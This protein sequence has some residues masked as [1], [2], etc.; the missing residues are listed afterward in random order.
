MVSIAYRQPKKE[1]Y[2]YFIKCGDAVK[3]GV[4]DNP[5]DR[6][7]TLS[8]GSPEKL[9]ILDALEMMGD[10]EAECHRRLRHLRINRE[11]FRYTNE[12]DELIMEL[13]RDY[14]EVCPECGAVH[15]RCDKYG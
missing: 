1:K 4:S 7:D 3:I 5:E 15:R 13:K 6:L 11:W 8:T 2:L 10:H 14:F 9:V 12:I